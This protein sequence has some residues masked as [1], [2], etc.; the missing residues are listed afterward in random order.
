MV[1]IGE[2]SPYTTRMLPHTECLSDYPSFQTYIYIYINLV[3]LTPEALL[4]KYEF[5]LRTATLRVADVKPHH[6][7]YTVQR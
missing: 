7:I 5:E 6:V 2:V 4:P 3:R 1:S